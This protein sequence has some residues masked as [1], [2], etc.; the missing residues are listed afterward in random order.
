MDDL[1]Q[2]GK[3]PYPPSINK[4]W[5]SRQIRLRGTGKII[6]CVYRLPAVVKYVNDVIYFLKM[7]KIKPFFAEKLRIELLI[8]PPDRK[9]R[10]IDNVCKGILDALQYAGI[11]DDDF[12]IWQ[13]SVERREVR[14][15]GE[16][17]F[18]IMSIGDTT[19]A[20]I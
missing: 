2:K 17:E 1:I 4:Y 11:Y 18:T 3:L 15:H 12:K 13:L 14:K 10:D 20:T 8:Y 7:Q 9:K 16:V 19:H 5:G 6:K